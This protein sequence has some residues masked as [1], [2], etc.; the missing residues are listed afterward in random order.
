MPRPALIHLRCFQH[1]RHND[2]CRA[3]SPHRHRG[4][5]SRPLQ[6]LQR[7]VRVPLSHLRVRVSKD[8]LDLVVRMP[9][10]DQERSELMSKVITAES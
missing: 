10:V 4:N 9:G 8:L 6:C 3:R 2:R 7:Q 1:L 5:I